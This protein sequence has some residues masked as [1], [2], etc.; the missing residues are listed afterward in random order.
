MLKEA[1]VRKMCLMLMIENY[2]RMDI[3]HQ[4][5]KLTM[6]DKTTLVQGRVPFEKNTAVARFA[7]LMF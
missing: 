4:Y 5:H 7:V 2:S 3:E 1:E 6:L